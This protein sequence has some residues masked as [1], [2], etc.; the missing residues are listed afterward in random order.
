MNIRENMI[1]YQSHFKRENGFVLFSILKCLALLL[2]TLGQKTLIWKAL[3]LS[4]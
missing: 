4:F 2:A 1:L 3:M